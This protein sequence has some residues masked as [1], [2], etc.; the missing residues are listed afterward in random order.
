MGSA[1]S[2]R[3]TSMEDK[4]L[5]Q[6]EIINNSV[7]GPLQ[8]SETPENYAVVVVA[9]RDIPQQ[10]NDEESESDDEDE[11]WNERLAIL[12]DARQLK[13]LAEFFLQP[14][15]PVAVEATAAARCYLL[16]PS[17]RPENHYGRR[18]GRTRP[19]SKGAQTIEGTGR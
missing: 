5:A 7:S 17:I 10:E 18:R 16:Q 1:Q 2:T 11:E 8:S 3:T 4:D 12:E 15:K 14:E 19:H 13:R 9:A 6:Q